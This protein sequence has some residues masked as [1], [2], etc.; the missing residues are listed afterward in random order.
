MPNRFVMYQ[1]VYHNDGTFKLVEIKA[2]PKCG[3]MIPDNS[4]WWSIH[5]SWHESLEGK[6]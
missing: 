1:V 6:K 2:C 3:S 4:Q 5:E